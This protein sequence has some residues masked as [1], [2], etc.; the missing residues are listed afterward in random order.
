MWRKDSLDSPAMKALEGNLEDSGKI[1]EIH[2]SLEID[3]SPKPKESSHSSSFS[4]CSKW[5][6]Y[7]HVLLPTIEDVMLVE[8]SML[9]S[10]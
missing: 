3:I 1:K 5:C 10:G 7:F 9:Y 2:G 6:E 8:N 4:L